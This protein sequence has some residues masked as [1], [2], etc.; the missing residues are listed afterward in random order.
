PHRQARS[1]RCSA[2]ARVK[3]RTLHSVAVV[4]KC[5]HPEG[6]VAFRVTSSGEGPSHSREITSFSRHLRVHSFGKVRNTACIRSHVHAVAVACEAHVEG[7]AALSLVVRLSSSAFCTHRLRISQSGPVFG[8]N[9]VEPS[10]IQ[11][12]PL[13]NARPSGCR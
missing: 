13:Y 4:F 8:P 7:Y 5:N 1:Y 9:S 2:G 12:E 11:W 6:G 10:M 3:A